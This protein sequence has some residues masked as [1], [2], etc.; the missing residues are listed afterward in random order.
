[1]S[2]SLQ[3]TGQPSRIVLY[4]AAD[5]L[6]WRDKDFV[7][8]YVANVL[9]F[10]K[11]KARL[12]HDMQIKELMVE[13]VC[14]IVEGMNPK[15]IRTKLEAFTG[16]ESKKKAGAASTPKAAVPAAAAAKG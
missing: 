9:V 14:S 6:W 11:I 10:N 8:P 4:N 2:D 15:L 1:M 3:P 5:G 7:P 12:H 13:G 16:G